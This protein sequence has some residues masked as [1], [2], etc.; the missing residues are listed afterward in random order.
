M[1]SDRY[2]MRRILLIAGLLGLL[3]LLGSKG[4]LVEAPAYWIVCLSRAPQ[5]ISSSVV[6]TL[7]TA[8]KPVDM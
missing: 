7:G 1:L 2:S 6:W 5:T 8:L 3:G 4:L